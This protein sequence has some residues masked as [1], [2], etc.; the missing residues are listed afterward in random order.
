MMAN[1]NL[2]IFDNSNHQV[3]VS[4]EKMTLKQFQSIYNIIKGNSNR[5]DYKC[6]KAIQV[7]LENLRTLN[8]KVQQFIDTHGNCA[9]VA[10]KVIVSYVDD[11]SISHDSFHQFESIPSPHH[12]AVEE[13]AIK[14]SFSLLINNKIE[15][16]DVN[17]HIR[18]LVSQNEKL[19]L[20]ASEIEKMIFLM[21]SQVTA[22]IKIK[23]VDY[24]IAES[25]MN[26]IK[27]WFNSLPEDDSKLHLLKNYSHFIPVVLPV[28]LFI[29]A[30][31]IC[32][33]QIDSLFP[34]NITENLI[35]KNYLIIIIVLFLVFKLA[36]FFSMI[37]ENKIDGICRHSYIK[38][39]DFDDKLIKKS[40]KSNSRNKVIA[41]LSFIFSFLCS[42]F[43]SYIYDLIKIYILKI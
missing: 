14:Y 40:E 17:I 2:E 4:D 27:A 19:S 24:L 8:F 29:I 5:L 10:S 31:L 23:Y 35:A 32:Y 30:M 20:N 42:I 18:S 3:L 11:N 26:I 7:D 22:A 34:N 33:Q 43:S 1:S 37:I 12:A 41:F 28:I 25:L 6:K 13:I 39:N 9:T 15:N 21:S 16:Y 36:K 38:L